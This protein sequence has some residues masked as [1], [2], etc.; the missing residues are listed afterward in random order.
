MK[1]YILIA[2]SIVLSANLAQAQNA[3]DSMD[4]ATE[5]KLAP[6][7]KPQPKTMKNV[8]NVTTYKASATIKEQ[9]FNDALVN[10]DDAQVELR[11]E[12][13][14]ITAKYNE[15]LGEKEK[16]I[17]ACKVYKK[18]IK[19]INTKMKNVEKSKQIINKNLEVK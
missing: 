6:M 5:V 2:F 3:F 7:A 19:N 15:A 12:L 13:A 11:Q 9:K 17:A 14:V 4:N 10:L 1:K 16:A 8:S 18:E